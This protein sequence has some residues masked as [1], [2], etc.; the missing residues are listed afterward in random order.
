MH[1]IA[2]RF[3]HSLAVF[4]AKRTYHVW[5]RVQYSLLL[6]AQAA[7]YTIGPAR[8]CNKYIYSFIKTYNLVSNPQ[9]HSKSIFISSSFIESP[10]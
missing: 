9:K 3:Y 6:F 1:C 5:R 8:Q 2:F 10:R 4:Q 7:E